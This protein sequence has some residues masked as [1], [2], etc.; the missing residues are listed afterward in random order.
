MPIGLSLKEK[1]FGM[2]NEK[3]LREAFAHIIPTFGRVICF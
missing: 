3:N 1:Q 2:K